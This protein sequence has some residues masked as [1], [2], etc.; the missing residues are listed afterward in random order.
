MVDAGRGDAARRGGRDD[1]GRVQTTA[2]PDLYDA[3]VGGDARKGEEGGGGGDFEEARLQV[4]G[5]VKHVFE[6]GGEQPIVDQL[7]GEAD[8]FVEADEVRAGVGVDAAPLRLQDRAE[9]GAGR[10]LDRQSTRLNSS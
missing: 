3:I 7:A 1:V 5:N 6:E 9:E 4:G 2:E 10:A 8:A